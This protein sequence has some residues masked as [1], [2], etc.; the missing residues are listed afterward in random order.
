[1]KHI[2]S[3]NMLPVTPTAPTAKRA[4][5]PSSPVGFM[6][7]EEPREG[8]TA[9]VGSATD[10][11][12]RNHPGHPGSHGQEQGQKPETPPAAVKPGLAMGSPTRLA[13]DNGALATLLQL[14]EQEP[15]TP[16]KT[17]DPDAD[18]EP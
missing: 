18:W 16:R 14:Q 2:T 10:G 1:L 4:E 5:R 11:G 15:P 7:D 9:P 12:R 13:A 17:F 8:E 6:A 3:V